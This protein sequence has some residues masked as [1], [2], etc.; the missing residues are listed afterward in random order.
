MNFNCK[1]NPF[2][3]FTKSIV[4]QVSLFVLPIF[5]VGT[6]AL[7]NVTNT[8]IQDVRFVSGDLTLLLKNYIHDLERELMIK[9]DVLL[10]LAAKVIKLEENFKTTDSKIKLYREAG[11]MRG[12]VI[13]GAVPLSQQLLRDGSIKNRPPQEIIA[14]F[15]TVFANHLLQIF[16]WSVAGYGAE[17]EKMDFSDDFKEY[18]SDAVENGQADWFEDE[19]QN[20]SIVASVVPFL[21]NNQVRGVYVALFDLSRAYTTFDAADSLALSNQASK[22]MEKRLLEDQKL[23]DALLAHQLLQN[24]KIDQANVEM[25]QVFSRIQRS[26]IIWVTSVSSIV[27]FMSMVLFWWFGS[28][29]VNKLSNLLQEVN[30]GNLEAPVPYIHHINE[31]GQI[32]KGIDA[33]KRVSVRLIRV[34][35]GV[36]RSSNMLASGV[37][38]Q[39]AA[40]EETNS[41]IEQ[42]ANAAH[43]NSNSAKQAELDIRQAE[44]IVQKARHSINKLNVTMKEVSQFSIK[45]KKVVKSIDGIAFQTNI[46]AL[47]AA[48]E[49]SRAGMAGQGFAVVAEEVRSLALKTTES[50]RGTEIL[51]TESVKKINQCTALAEATS[52]EIEQVTHITEGVAMSFTSIAQSS[53]EQYSAIENIRNTV[54]EID[55]IV[56][57]NAAA[58]SELTETAKLISEESSLFG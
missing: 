1:L 16:Y 38:E 47:N 42:V 51:I 43:T 24:K 41:A 20:N 5:L 13:N 56:Q 11:E 4:R 6:I 21:E 44:I 34:G 10:G 14:E 29:R 49:A 39:A 27:L 36:G 23:K 40:L 8:M 37:N 25:I 12:G 3:W 15:K 32:A 28:N 50:A 35:E 54:E 55:A 33:F 48:V 57:N 19:F 17:L 7:V 46:L 9:S 18:V 30:S 52:L 31:V 2:Q 26:M 22:A 58:A 45:I 53:N